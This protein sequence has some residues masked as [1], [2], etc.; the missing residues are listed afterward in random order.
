MCPCFHVMPDVCINFSIRHF[1]CTFLGYW[2]GSGY[3]KMGRITSGNWGVQRLVREAVLNWSGDQE[4]RLV[5]TNG[6]CRDLIPGLGFGTGNP[7]CLLVCCAILP[8]TRRR[9][10]KLIFGVSCNI[11]ADS[12]AAFGCVCKQSTQDISPAQALLLETRLKERQR[13]ACI[14]YNQSEEV[15]TCFSIFVA[16]VL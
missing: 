9:I 8:A 5:P 14:R 4:C 10:P 13:L 2:R 1:S 7:D 3:P 6:V 16:M 11:R 12:N 15:L